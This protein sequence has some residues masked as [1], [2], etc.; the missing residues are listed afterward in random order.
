MQ[1]Y[2]SHIVSLCRRKRQSPD[3]FSALDDLVA[4]KGELGSG[5][6]NTSELTSGLFYGYIVVDLRSLSTTY[7][8]IAHW[9]RGP[10]QAGSPDCNGIPRREARSDRSVRLR[11]TDVGGSRCAATTFARERL[12]ESCAKEGNQRK[13]GQRDR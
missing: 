1:P 4:A 10:P 11:R 2:M 13:S 6:I 8:A 3:Y 7:P 9:H 5:H 12:H